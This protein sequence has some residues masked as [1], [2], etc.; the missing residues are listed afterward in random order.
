M[1]R[2]LAIMGVIDER[3]NLKLVHEK[4]IQNPDCHFVMIGSLAKINAEDLPREANI[5]YPV[6]KGYSEL[7]NYL[8]RFDIA[9][10]P[11]AMN[12]ATR[13][14]KTLEYMA[15]GRPIISTAIADVV[16]DYQYH[17]EIISSA[18]GF[19]QCIRKLLADLLARP[20]C[21]FL[22]FWC[23][24]FFLIWSKT[25]QVFLGEDTAP[26]ALEIAPGMNKAMGF[27]FLRLNNQ[28]IHRFVTFP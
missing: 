20:C 5:H 23:L 18:A 10:M 24:H 13:S 1:G 3:T 11:S 7:S 22:C 12:E 2:L 14:T 9:M 19:T 6:M 8:K 25:C 26:E 17:V 4:A 28:P 16:R 15:A 27:L 21:T